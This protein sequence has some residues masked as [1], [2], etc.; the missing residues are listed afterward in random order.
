MELIRV[1]RFADVAVEFDAR[2]RRVVWCSAATVD[3][4]GRPRS[5]IL[6]PIWE[7]ATGWITTRRHG[8]KERH[9]T[10]T[11][12]ISLAYVAEIATPVYA[13][14][15]AAWEDDPGEKR[16]IW[17]LIAAAPPPL[18]FDPAPIYG[19]P[20]DPEF[21]LLRVVP[22]R[23]EVSTVPVERRVWQTRA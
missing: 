11:P 1:E 23:V 8:V 17:D 18:G 5:R 3:A 15:H 7:G 4:R 20:D 22:W 10:R 16:R 6:H 12:Y 14:C 9:L 13:E 21:G 19:R 2:V